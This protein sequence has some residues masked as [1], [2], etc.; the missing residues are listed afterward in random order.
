MKSYN[1][2]YHSLVNSVIATTGKPFFQPKLTINSPNDKY[3]QEADTVADKVMQMEMPSLQK[4]SGTDSF[5]LSSPVSITPLQRK[6]D[7]CKEEEKMQ[8][9]E[10]G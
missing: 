3:E 2:Q 10:I 8:R 9:K 7:D 4:K 6:C 1:K 5:F